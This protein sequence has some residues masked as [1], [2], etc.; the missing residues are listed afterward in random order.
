MC[1]PEW[2]WRGENGGRYSKSNKRW[3]GKIVDV[4]LPNYYLESYVD[5]DAPYFLFKCDEEDDNEY[6]MQYCD[7]FKFAIDN[8]D[9]SFVLPNK[10]PVKHVD[11]KLH[12]LCLKAMCQMSHLD[13]AQHVC[14]D[15][16]PDEW[17]QSVLDA[18]ENKNL[19]ADNI[20]N[21]ALT[22][23]WQ[24]ARQKEGEDISSIVDIREGKDM[25]FDKTEI[26][27][28]FEE[29]FT[30]L[31]ENH[32]NQRVGDYIDTLK[33]TPKESAS[34]ISRYFAKQGRGLPWGKYCFG[35]SCPTCRKHGKSKP[36]ETERKTKEQ[37]L[38]EWFSKI[39]L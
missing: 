37:A 28:K 8:Q 19:V 7:V 1:V 29:R 26:A 17:I 24:L 30:E 5:V 15:V 4:S 34:L 11:E 33:V 18:L 31:Y 21:L 9:S 22:K 13:M 14:V 27:L 12:L 35:G 38:A 16:L 23:Y 32:A 39:R 3:G 25:G 36:A 6:R 10:M 2:W 20:R